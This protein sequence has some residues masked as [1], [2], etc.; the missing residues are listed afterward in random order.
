MIEDVEHFGAELDVEVFRNALHGEIL[1]Y[2]EVQVRDSRTSKDVSSGVATK[3]ET[4][5][6]ARRQ[7]TQ[8]IPIGVRIGWRRG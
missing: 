6:V 8:L 1:E 7:F 5:Q 2:R 3:V 4:P